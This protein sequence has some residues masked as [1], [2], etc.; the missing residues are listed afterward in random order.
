MFASFDL[1]GHNL[2]ANT[3]SNSA[4]MGKTHFI[5]DVDPLMG[6]IS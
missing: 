6:I 3:S 4:M 2:I 5:V 1:C